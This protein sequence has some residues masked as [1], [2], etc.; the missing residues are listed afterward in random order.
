MSN[1][2]SLTSLNADMDASPAHYA[3][4][5]GPSTNP[6]SVHMHKAVQE[7]QLTKQAAGYEKLLIKLEADIR[8][9]IRLE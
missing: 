6:S 1:Q 8:Q 9:H 5:S 3:G 2:S 7:R 4:G